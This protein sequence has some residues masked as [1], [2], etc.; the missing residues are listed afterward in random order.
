MPPRI[1]AASIACVVLCQAATA[2]AARPALP[3]SAALQT[4]GEW[5]ETVLYRFG[6]P[7]AAPEG[8]GAFPQA[9]VAADASGDLFGTTSVGGSNGNGTVFELAP[10][11]AG[12]EW[13]ETLLHEFLNEGDDGASPMDRPVFDDRGVLYGTTQ[14]GG[15]YCHGLLCVGGTVF[16]LIP[17][18]VNA[19]PW[20]EQVLLSFS[21]GNPGGDAPRGDLL[22]G[23]GT[24]FGTAA[25]TYFGS[26][27]TAFSV[28]TGPSGASERI[29]HAFSARDARGGVFPEGGV[30]SD[31]RGVLYG[32]T[33]EGGN[34]GDECGS[35]GCGVVYQ[36]VPPQRRGGRWRERVLY[37]FSGPD[38][39]APFASLLMGRRGALYGTTYG[40]GSRACEEGCGLVFELSPP[41]GGDGPWTETIVHAFGTAAG[42][43]YWPLSA[44][45]EDRD[46]VLYGTTLSGGD[47]AC[48]GGA[49]CGVVFALRPRRDGSDMWTERILHRFR[50][51]RRRDG[52]GPAAG[53]LLAGEHRLFGTTEIGGGGKCYNGCGTVFAL[54]PG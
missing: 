20:A 36:L 41:R 2:V 31:R 51:L 16:G 34:T 5:H 32:T 19:G 30:I 6:G 43:G 7:E 29:L 50:G 54:S 44:L 3:P 26:A 28:V 45:I 49:G 23:R 21:D 40:G 52:E 38:G 39:S 13:H 17:A 1:V 48:G 46:G 35:A 24:L 18:P 9:G 4:A 47:V 22:A 42:D 27:G 11:T 14:A 37:A 10:A 12:R 15:E 33:L 25:L 8:D 53:L